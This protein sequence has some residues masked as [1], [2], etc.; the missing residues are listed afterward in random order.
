MSSIF[1]SERL[2]SVDLETGMKVRALLFILIIVAATTSGFGQHSTE[3]TISLNEQFFD[4]LI[5]A[6][7]QNSPP[8]EFQLSK[9]ERTRATSPGAAAFA[10]GPDNG[11]ST[12][13][14]LREN[15]SV[16]TAVKL[17][18]GRINALVA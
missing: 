1:T 4:S 17:H 15:K 9:T 6:I 3:I 12:V 8:P 13:R 14:L 18:D 7:Y 10:P 11:C 16:R 5:D 2:T